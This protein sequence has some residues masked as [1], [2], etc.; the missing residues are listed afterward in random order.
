MGKSVVVVGAGVGGLAVAI[1]LAKMGFNVDVFEQAST[2]GGKMGQLRKDGYRFD[3]GPSLFTLPHLLNPLIELNENLDVDLAFEK[4]ENVCRYHYNDGKVINAYADSKRFVAEVERVLGEPGVNVEKYLNKVAQMYNLTAEMFIFSPFARWETFSSDVG[5]KVARQLHKLDMLLTMHQRNRKSFK[6]RH[7][8]QLFD[9]YGTYNGSNPYR[10][11]ATLTMI[12]HLEHSD[13]AYFPKKGMYSIIEQL[14]LHAENLGVRFYFNNRVDEVLFDKRKAV[15]VRVG[16]SLHRANLVVSD[17]DVT[18]FYK[19]LMPHKRQPL[20]LKFMEK[21]SSAVI[22]YW[23]VNRQFSELQ[24]H[25]IFFAEDYR[26]EFRHLFKLKTL[27]SDPTVYVFISNKVA[28]SDAP[29]GCENWFVMVNAPAN[30]GQYDDEMFL[31]LRKNIISK[32]SKV[33]GTDIG[34]NIVSETMATPI[35]IERDTSSDGGAIYGHSS[36]NRLSAFLRHPNRLKRYK[37]LHFVGGSVH[38][39]GGIPLCI[40]SAD[41]VTNDIKKENGLV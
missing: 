32:L 37:D 21:S 30:F 31:N 11:P 24:L 38:P 10:A 36:N 27:Y 13:G 16:E 40:A 5:R 2:S 35:N 39:G 25:N 33:L 14:Q 20:R 19:H 34:Q 12:A 18:S 41:I 9:R 3:T 15:G 28:Y 29:H 4:L 1:K 6:S 26:Q 7:L 17:M 8:V 23:G 22:F